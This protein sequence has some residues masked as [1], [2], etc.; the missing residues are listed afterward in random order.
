MKKKQAARIKSRASEVIAFASQVRED[1]L[2]MAVNPK[3]TSG[4]L[5]YLLHERGD[6]EAARKNRLVDVLYVGLLASDGS[7]FD[8]CFSDGQPITFRLGTGEVIGGWDIGISLL[9]VGDR[10]TL[11]LPAS[12]GYG[13][14]GVEDIP[15]NSELI[16]YVEVV[17]VRG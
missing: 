12:L 1:Y 2:A 3:R 15:P 6:G 13:R 7:V 16:F 10:A 17:G 5:G 4:G 9:S 8:E 14:E 11:F